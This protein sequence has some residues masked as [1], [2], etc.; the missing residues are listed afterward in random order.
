ML[1]ETIKSAKGNVQTRNIGMQRS[2]SEGTLFITNIGQDG[3]D[4]SGPR[5]TY[6]G[7][8]RKIPKR[9]SF[10]TFCSNNYYDEYINNQTTSEMSSNT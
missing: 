3:R 2:S 5:E 1:K 7:V 10:L 9:G 6:S 4:Q 8:L